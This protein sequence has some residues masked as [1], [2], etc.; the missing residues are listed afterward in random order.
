MKRALSAG[1][2]L[3]LSLALACSGG[4]PP[5]VA[6]VD[7]VIDAWHTAASVADEERYFGLMTSDAVFLGTDPGE[8]WTVEEF[9]AYAQPHFSQ[10]RGWTYVPSERHVMFSADG[11]LA[12]FDERLESEKYGVLRGT[13]VLR[14][15]GGEWRLAHYSM[16]FAVPNAAAPDVVARIRG[17]GG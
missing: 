2:I 14:H 4:Q 11:R 9:R 15:A 5:D 10:G 7:R 13:G 8:R 17:D 3:G 6:D 12:W 16:T 1:A